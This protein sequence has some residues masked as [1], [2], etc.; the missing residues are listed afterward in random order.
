MAGQVT[1][2][3]TEIAFILYDWPAGQLTCYSASM[4]F[5]TEAHP[6]WTVSPTQIQW[7]QNIA[8]H[9]RVMFIYS[10]SQQIDLSQ[11]P[12]ETLCICQWS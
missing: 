3:P 11:Y 2:F 8:L 7:H 6:T 1:T 4:T 9:Y 10:S 5:D 12:K